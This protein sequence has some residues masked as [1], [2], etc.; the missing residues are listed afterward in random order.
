MGSYGVWLR[1]GASSVSIANCT[2]HDVGAGGVRIGDGTPP[3]ITSELVLHNSV[4]DTVISHGG[5]VFEAGQGVLVQQASH[6][7]I[8][9]N[10]IFDLYQNGVALGWTWD[11]SAAD[12][13]AAMNNTVSYNHIHRIGQRVTSDMGCVYTLGVSPGTS[14]HHNLCHDV[15]SFD[16][17]GWGLY[18]DQ[19]SSNISMFNNIVYGTRCAPFMHHWGQNNTFRNNILVGNGTGCCCQLCSPGLL[20]SQPEP[21][22]HNVSFV[23][24][25]NIA[26][27]ETGMLFAPPATEWNHS[28]LSF[29]RNT[30]YT[31]PGTTPWQDVSVDCSNPANSSAA[32]EQSYQ[33]HFPG[34]TAGNTSWAQWRAAGQDTH[35]SVGKDPL[36]VNLAGPPN[37]FRASLCA[38]RCR[39]GRSTSEQSVGYARRKGT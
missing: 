32:A 12:I 9:H 30:Y 17:G 37:P 7:V 39:C 35:S 33:Y 34:T 22:G 6:T 13:A 1:S 23:W 19:A 18:F 38:P 3:S 11:Y 24:D 5:R 20:R 15:Q 36:F 25:R 10:D 4:L 31:A 26:Y 29:D 21:G 28:R 14:V 8:S 2:V 27:L 16:Y